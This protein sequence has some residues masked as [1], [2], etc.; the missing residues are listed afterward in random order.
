MCE[1][2]RFHIHQYGKVEYLEALNP[3]VLYQHYQEIITTSP[4]DICVIGDLDFDYVKTVMNKHFNKESNHLIDIPRE[5]ICK[6]VD[7]V[8]VIDEPANVKQAK[9]TLGYRSN[10]SYD[11]ELYEASVLFTSILGGG[12]NSKLF[13]KIREEES[14]CY[15]IYSKLEKFK[16]IIL[17]T[18][19]IN[20]KDKD[21]VVELIKEEIQQIQNGN[22]DENEL[23]IAKKSLIASLE[24]ASD[25]PNSFI[26]FYYRQLLIDRELDIDQIIKKYEKITIEDVIQV[27]QMIALDT[28]HFLRPDE[29]VVDED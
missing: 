27:S 9:L 17:I 24:S 13:K 12:A 18:S 16:S 19:G 6:K 11:H 25:Y 28:I 15:Y 10:I 26:N 29:V 4:I 23:K 3:Q 5:E 14:L 7:T 20:Y 2:E 1:N 22:V 8:K 21:K